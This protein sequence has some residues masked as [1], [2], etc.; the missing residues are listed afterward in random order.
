MPKK[1]KAREKARK[2]VQWSLEKKARHPLILDVRKNSNF[3]DYF[4]ILSG[5]SGVQV[6][7]IYNALID[8]ASRDGLSIAHSEDDAEDRW[9]LIDCLDVIV[10]I[11]LEE[12]RKYYDLEYL[13]R[14]AKHV[15][16]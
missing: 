3:C 14:K 16:F 12:E 5:E 9:L 6:R 10:H 2:F 1:D 11:F 15:R 13:W 7:A 8:K 4:V